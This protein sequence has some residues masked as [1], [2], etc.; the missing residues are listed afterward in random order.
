MAAG[1]RCPGQLFLALIQMI[2]IPLVFA[3]II[4][5]LAATENLSQLKSI[6]LRAILFFVITTAAAIVIGIC[7]T[8]VF[9]PGLLIDGQTVESTL[10]T[11]LVVDEA[12]PAMPTFDDLP[13]KVLTL[14]PTNPAEL[15][16]RE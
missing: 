6:G 10:G 12:A 2:V 3:S 11:K 14:L 5:G 9:Q 13:Q 7:L 16:G 1:W 4:R 15:D 8:L